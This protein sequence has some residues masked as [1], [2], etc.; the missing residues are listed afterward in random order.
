M[1]ARS[2]AVGLLGAVALT[3]VLAACDAAA[4]PPPCPNPFDAEL[5]VGEAALTRKSSLGIGYNCPPVVRGR[6]TA[7]AEVVVVGTELDTLRLRYGPDGGLDGVTYV[8]GD[9]DNDWR[10]S[11][12]RSGTL[13]PAPGRGRFE[14]VV[15]NGSL[16]P[17]SDTIRGQ[18]YVAE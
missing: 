9:G 3:A 16:F 13:G 11:H 2:P 8:R 17:V 15:H 4:E 1:R 10:P 7:T 18:F 5:A 14:V 12:P 6:V